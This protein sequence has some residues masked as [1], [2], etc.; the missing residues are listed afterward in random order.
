MNLKD[1]RTEAN[2]MAAFVGEAQAA[3]KY[4]I[5]AQKA[6]QDGYEQIASIFEETASNE[7]AHALQ[8][9]KLLHGGLQSTLINLQD[10]AKGEHFEWSEMYKGFALEAEREGLTQAAHL[11]ELTAKI[12][13]E[14]EKRYQALIQNMETQS[15]FTKSGETIWIC[16]YCGHIHTGPEAPLVCPLC[17]HPQAFFQE[18][19]ENYN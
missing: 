5:F 11:F 7:R 16:R 18:K 13:S 19:A 9:F 17:Q 8:W 14:H 12:E 2:L 15:V 4:W 6:R 10:A 1:S 3:E